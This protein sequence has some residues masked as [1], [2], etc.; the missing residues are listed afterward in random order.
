[1]KY[2]VLAFLLAAMIKTY[3]QPFGYTY[4]KQIT[5]PSSSVA[6][7][8][9]L[10]DF[11]VLI[12]FTDANLRATA[13]GGHVTNSNGYDI[14]FT[15][16]D[17]LTLLDHQIESYTP[18][19]GQY[20]AWV[21]VPLL[22]ASANTVIQMYYGNSGVFTNTSTTG[23]WDSHYKGV[24]HFN[25]SVADYTVNGNNLTDNSTG[26]RASGQI[27]QGRDLDNSVDVTSDLAG[28]YLRL[29]NGVFSGISSFTFEG[30]VFLD[31]RGTNWERIFD[32]GQSTVVNF[33]LCPTTGTG[34]PAPTRARITVNNAANEQG[35]VSANLTNTGSWIHWVVILDN[36]ASTMSVYRN[37]A[38]LMSANGVTVTPQNLEPST[39]NYFGRSQYA[40]DHYIDAGFD[41]FRIS[42]VAR[43]AG[44]VTT[45]Y[46][47]QFS[48]ATFYTVSAE[49][50][51]ST[52]CGPLPIELS[53]FDAI[54]VNHNHVEVV[55][56]T[57]TETNNDYFTVERS[58]NGLKW[59]AL[60]VV[61]G[62]GNSMHEL[63][64]SY[65]DVHPL[66]GRSYYR[67]RQTD[68]DNT[69]T[70]SGI[71]T[72]M[73]DIANDVIVYQHPSNREII[74]EWKGTEELGGVSVL[75]P[76]GQRINPPVSYRPGKIVFNAVGLAPG[77]YLLNIT[78]AGQSISRKV[79]VE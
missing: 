27:G 26:T 55:W 18:T 51:S 52:L 71:A 8:A 9:D 7:G 69:T 10:T 16:S 25:G 40:A 64:Y 39:A 41:E 12:S 79:I 72:A 32:F 35:P 42:S 74:I 6:G 70:Y 73:I 48:P 59:E 61:A 68:Y 67:L 76:V 75:N 21:R 14:V 34:G 46:N 45:S 58:A 24:W 13:N 37:G 78:Y 29:G 31:R 63:D 30:W 66:P 36:A 60:A 15:S 4:A 22:S 23:V 62:A 53:Y 3:G 38:F 20:I 28:Q 54:S 57:L 65:L 44:W 1:M 50:A 2:P 77:I 19:N 43:T 47:N 17:C 56:T 49:A 11:P 33:F 5:I